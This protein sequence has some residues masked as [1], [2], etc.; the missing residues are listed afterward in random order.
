[1][2]VALSKSSPETA[3]ADT[4]PAN[5]T[6]YPHGEEEPEEQVAILEKMLAYWRGKSYKP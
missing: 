5:N 1:M 6:P 2:G 3:T 4:D